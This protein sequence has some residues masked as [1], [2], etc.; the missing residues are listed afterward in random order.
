MFGG[1]FLSLFA[2]QMLQIGFGNFACAAAV[3]NLVNHR[4]GRL[5]KYAQRWHHNFNFVRT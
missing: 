1:D 5:G 4:H 3:D 2:I